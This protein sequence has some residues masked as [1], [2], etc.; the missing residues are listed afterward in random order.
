MFH[1][2]FFSIIHRLCG[3]QMFKEPKMSFSLLVPVKSNLFIISG[4]SSC[5]ILPESLFNVM[6]NSF[7]DLLHQVKS[8][9]C[10]LCSTDAVFPHGLSNC[11]EDADMMQYASQL[12]D[13]WVVT[14]FNSAKNEAYTHFLGI[15]RLILAHKLSCVSQAWSKIYRGNSP[16][17]IT[18]LVQD[19]IVFWEH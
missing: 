13:G 19:G 17:K 7:F 2:I 8:G 4:M 12:E 3:E 14:L 15:K 6:G 18:S 11:S 10:L 16:E 1:T 9:C 5:I